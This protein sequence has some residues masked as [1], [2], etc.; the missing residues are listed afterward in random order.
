MFSNHALQSIGE[1]TPYIALLG[2]APQLSPQLEHIV[3]AAPLQD[4]TGIDGSRH[5]HRLR[6]IT[7]PSMIEALVER[8]LTMI[9][10]SGPTPLPGELL[11]LRPGD[12]VEIFRRTTKDRPSS[13]GP[14]TVRATDIDHG[15]ITAQWQNRNIDV[16][17][18]SI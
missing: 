1:G 4:E 13:V 12:Q 3:G 10:Q 7:V 14:A 15:K 9:N 6:E 11:S 2:R 18:E 5:V 8:R 17:L 16:P